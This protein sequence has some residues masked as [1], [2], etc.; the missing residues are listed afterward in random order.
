MK[1][2]MMHNE[3]FQYLIRLL[4]AILCASVLVTCGDASDS[5]TASS[6]EVE[7]PQVAE[8]FE[9]TPSELI[10]PVDEN[11]FA[12][13]AD[14]FAD[15]R[16]LRYQV[17]GFDALSTSQKELLYYLSQ[18]ALSGRDIMYDQNY[19]HNLRIRRTIEEVIQH[20]NGDRN[21]ESF[22]NFITYAKQ[23]WFAN[24]IH[25]HYS[26]DKFEPGFSTEFLEKLLNE[27][28]VELNKEAFEVVFNDEDSK[29]VNLDASKLRIQ[30]C[31]R[32]PYIA[33]QKTRW[34]SCVSL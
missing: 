31:W 18:A 1:N 30:F 16:M 21:T 32:R 12:Y 23:M 3:Y 15:I 19:K 10:E 13:E 22:N 28:N 14:R 17:A 27:S 20:Y 29:K 7:M 4:G 25:H 34:P 33:V 11:S 9:A 6:T 5:S 8:N 26:N 24:G 2:K